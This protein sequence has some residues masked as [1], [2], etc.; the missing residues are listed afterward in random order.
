MVSQAGAIY[1]NKTPANHSGG[2]GIH[3]S[4][5]K[6][7]EPFKAIEYITNELILNYL[8]EPSII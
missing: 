4:R 8:R 7:N 1:I 3:I 2:N 5:G 6:S